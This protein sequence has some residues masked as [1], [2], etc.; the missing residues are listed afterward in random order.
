MAE[1]IIT[2][3]NFESEVLNSDIPVLVDFF[4]TWCG[5]CQALSPIIAEIANECEGKLKVC[6]LDIDD[7]MDLAQKY[8]VMS[9]PTVKLFKAGE[10]AGTHVGLTSKSELL[11]FI[12]AE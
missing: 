5:P 10:V 9:V 2:A 3:E 7:N 1:V 12:E 11:S 4:A 6:K 8:R